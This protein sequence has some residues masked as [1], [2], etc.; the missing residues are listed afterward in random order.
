MMRLVRWLLLP[1]SPV[2]AA[3][4]WLRNQLYDQDVLKSRSFRIPVVVVGNLA[5]GGTGKS[6]MTEYILDMVG[7]SRRVAVL[8]RGYGR[9]T[10]GFRYV[11]TTS[12]VAEVGDEPLQIK[13][14]FPENTVVVCEDRCRAIERIQDAHDAVL[15]DD[16]FQHRKLRPG[17][18]ILLFD[19]RSLGK[20]MLPLPAGDF[21]DGMWESHR[22]DV[23]VVTKCPP[24][25]HPETRFAIQAKLHRYSQAPVFFSE[26]SYL[27]PVDDTGQ[28]LDPET[29]KAQDVLLITGIADPAPLLSFLAPRTKSIR[30]LPY[31]DHHAF[32]GADIARIVSA[33]SAIASANKLI[34]ST[35][36]D[37]QRLPRELKRAFS[38]FYVPIGPHFLFGQAAEFES[39]VSS[40]FLTISL[41]KP[42]WPVLPQGRSPRAGSP[43]C[44]FAG[45]G[46][47][48]P[49]STP[50]VAADGFPWTG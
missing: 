25:V 8:S 3:L 26:I 27:D 45:R 42:L 4:A 47:S 37:F 23:I 50:A 39:M 1:V 24:N 21:R 12:T 48:C 5:V 6:P 18:A 41:M 13:R 35:E 44:A 43:R 40:A 17:F 15:L 31:P 38:V 10:K 46:C 22:A 14:K 28:T 11:E 30:H 2:Y 34:L 49:C 9:K 33:F 36:K 19:F 29:L 7:R 20:A 32:S 16:A